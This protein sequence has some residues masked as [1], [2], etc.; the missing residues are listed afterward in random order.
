MTIRDNVTAALNGET[1]EWTPFLVKNWYFTHSGQVFDEWRSLF[2]QGLGFYAGCGT[3]RLEEHGVRETVESRVEGDDL[4]RITKK[5]TPIGTI[6]R[7]TLDSVSKPR[8]IEW[9]I[10]HF[11]KEPK[12]YKIRQWIIE[13]TESVPQY[14]AYEKLAE[15]ETDYRITI[16]GGGRTPALSVMVDYAGMERFSIDLASEVEELFDLYE[17]QKRLFLEYTRLIAEGPGR[18]L[19]W[20]ENL[21]APMLGP[22]RYR[23][24]VL[25]IYEEAVPVLEAGGKRV[26]VHYDG[27]L[28]SIADAVAEAPFHIVQALTE[29]PEGDMMLDECR[30]AWPDKTLWV[31]VNL[32]LYNLPEDALRDA[33]IAMRERAGKKGLVFAMTE[34]VPDNWATTVP[35]ILKTL[36]ELG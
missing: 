30:A 22:K 14:D 33:I 29:P 13:H 9:T 35:L 11:V 34:D 27:Q 8:A 26:G 23:D 31:N 17:A 18:F 10:E 4:Y 7:V 24:L 1:P 25:P 21:T 3:V 19:I 6:Q 16:V 32:D 2:D 5:E 20:G 15:M 28:R 36:Q 12:D